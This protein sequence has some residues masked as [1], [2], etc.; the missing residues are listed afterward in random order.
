MSPLYPGPQ[1]L[2]AQPR[3]WWWEMW[4]AEGSWFLNLLSCSLA[5][6]GRRQSCALAWSLGTCLCRCCCRSPRWCEGC[7]SWGGTPVLGEAGDAAAAPLTLCWTVLGGRHPDPST[8]TAFAKVVGSALSAWKCSYGP[9]PVLPHPAPLRISI[10][11][12]LPR[13]DV[14][15]FQVS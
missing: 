2:G 10:Y 14:W 4:L 1:G 6:C 9:V 8:S 15:I 13:T 7:G 12:H 11:A 5:P 3:A